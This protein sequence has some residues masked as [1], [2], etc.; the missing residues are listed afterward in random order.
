MVLITEHET[1][2]VSAKLEHSCIVVDDDDDFSLI[3]RKTLQPLGP[4]AP[5]HYRALGPAA[6]SLEA[7]FSTTAAFVLPL[8]LSLHHDSTFSLQNVLAIPMRA[9]TKLKALYS[10]TFLQ[11]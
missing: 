7:T 8:Q 2:K 9:S 3:Q 1:M 5:L 4:P 11:G 10:H 6:Q